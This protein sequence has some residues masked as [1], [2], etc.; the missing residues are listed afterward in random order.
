MNIKDVEKLAKISSQNIRFYK[1][2]GLIHLV[3]N[4]EN[5]YWKYEDEK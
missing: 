5:R 1:K 3:R 2:A 4:Q